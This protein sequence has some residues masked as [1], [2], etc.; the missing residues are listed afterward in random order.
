MPS[1]PSSFQPSWVISS[2]AS[3]NVTEPLVPIFMIFSLKSTTL[4]KQL[5][6][7]ITLPSHGWNYYKNSMS[8]KKQKPPSAM[9]GGTTLFIY[10]PCVSCAS[11]AWHRARPLNRPWCR[12]GRRR[13]SSYPRGWLPKK[14]LLLHWRKVSSWWF[15]SLKRTI[16]SNHM[17]GIT[18]KTRASKVKPV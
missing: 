12:P 3:L 14:G 18:S 2:Q 13:W 1:Q 15:P 6:S 4:K 10:A 16:N 11:M 17:A 8:P 5:K 7:R 9:L